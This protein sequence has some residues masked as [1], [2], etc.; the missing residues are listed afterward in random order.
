MSARTAWFPLF[1]N[2]ERH[3]QRWDVN[4]GVSTPLWDLIFGTYERT[5]QS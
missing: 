5:P 1:K 2:H 3:H 4:F